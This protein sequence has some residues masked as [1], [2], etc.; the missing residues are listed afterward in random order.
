[1]KNVKK[2]ATRRLYDSA[3]A[4]SINLGLGEPDFM[5]PEVIRREATRV[6]NEERIGY[7]ANA[8]LLALRERIAEYHSADLSSPLSPDSICVTTGAE[9]ALFATVMTIA[10]PDDEVLLP[11]PCFNA[12]P[13]LVEIAGAKVTRY[14]MPASRGFEFD[15]KSFAEAL[16]DKTKLVF[17][18]SPSNPTGRV[19]GRDDL[20][21]IADKLAGTNIYIVSDEIYR[22]LYFDERP[23]S[24]SE[25]YDKSIIVT[26]LSKMMSMTGWRLGW[27]AGPEEVVRHITVMHQYVSTCA[28][29]VS[30]KAAIAVFT[31]EGRK[32][33]ADIRDE[34]R[35]RRDVAAGAIESHLKLPYIIGEGAY[36]VMLDVSRFGASEDVAWSLLK[37]K[38][39]TVPGS[40]FGAES[41]GYLRLSFSIEPSQVEEGIRRIAS[42]LNGL[43]K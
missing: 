15:Q 35:R 19:F 13:T 33:T 42:G 41:E 2:S 38:V 3:P 1:L 22:E 11:D 37:E 7:T 14:S 16:T 39:I 32:A 36:Y 31:D 12:Y 5:T 26:G 18:G 23:S 40:A 20:K 29:T 10:G 27:I 21:F 25:F 8:G 9:E 17:I 30:Q 28:S 24:V 6:I 34:L 4:G 43:S